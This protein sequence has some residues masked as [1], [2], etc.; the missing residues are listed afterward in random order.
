MSWY[1]MNDL[2]IH[3]NDNEILGYSG[4]VD[5]VENALTAYQD[6]D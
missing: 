2:H 1:K 5:S 3:L 4:K 6:L